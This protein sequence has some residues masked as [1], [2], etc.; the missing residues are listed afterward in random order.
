MHFGNAMYRVLNEKSIITASIAEQL[1]DQG[2]TTFAN[3]LWV[4]NDKLHMELG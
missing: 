1:K 4:G 3:A 2:N